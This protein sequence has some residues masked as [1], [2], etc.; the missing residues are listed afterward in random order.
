MAF[1]LDVVKIDRAFMRELAEG[2]EDA[3]IV[4]AMVQLA[5]NL[6]LSLTAEGVETQA[7]LDHLVAIGGVPVV[8]GLH[9]EPIDRLLMVLDQDRARSGWG[10]KSAVSRP[11]SH[12][13]SPAAP[14]SASATA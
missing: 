11:G 4:K 12:A 3:V 9:L 14:S 8:A 1:P 13:A 5:H 6:Q 7:Q 2:S 10:A